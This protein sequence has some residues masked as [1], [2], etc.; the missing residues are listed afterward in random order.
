MANIITLTREV[1]LWKGESECFYDDQ[2]RLCELRL[3]VWQTLW[4]CLETAALSLINDP[5]TQINGM[6]LS[7]AVM[8]SAWYVYVVV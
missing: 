4:H 8:S 7:Q 5:L 6:M 2:K 1:V 3:S